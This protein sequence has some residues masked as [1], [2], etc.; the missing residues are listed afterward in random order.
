[1]NFF[2]LKGGQLYTAPA[3]AVLPGITRKYVYDAAKLSGL[4][5]NETFLDISKIESIDAAFLSGTSLGVLPIRKIND[6]QLDTTIP[7]L[8]ELIK[9]YNILV[10]DYLAEKA[11]KVNE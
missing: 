7:E 6:I 11:R 10:Q 2:Y 4:V 9:N 8:K 5:V 3:K 1:M